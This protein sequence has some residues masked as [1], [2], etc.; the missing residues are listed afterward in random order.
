[1]ADTDYL[2]K[3][4]AKHDENGIY[5]NEVPLKLDPHGFPLRPQPSDDPMGKLI[6]IYVFG[7]SD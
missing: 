1:M 4:G 3:T 6:K 5:A 7:T 2:E